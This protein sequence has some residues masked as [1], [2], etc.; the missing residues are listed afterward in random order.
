[1]S[2]S[3]FGRLFLSH[4]A[5]ILLTTLVLGLFMS[6]LVRNHAVRT[7]Q[8]DLLV[9][10]RVVSQL[11]APDLR[12]GRVPSAEQLQELEQLAGATLWLI[13]REGRVIAGTPPNRWAKAFPEAADE[14]SALFAGEAQTWV[15]TSRRQTDRSIV[16]G[17]AVPGANPQTA[18]LLY[19]S[20][21]GVN[22][23]AQAVEKLLLYSL[24]IGILAALAFALV[25]ARG[26]TRPVADIS[27]AAARF[28]GGDYTSRT[29]ATG[30]DELGR[31]G[32]TFNAMA[33]ALAHAEENRRKFLADVTHELKTPVASIQAM[34]EALQDGLVKDTDQQHRYLGT[35]VGEA[36][37][38]D[39]LLRDLLALAEL[40]AGA[41]SI[42]KEPLDLGY[43]WHEQADRL[44][45]L[46]SS[47][48]LT[49]NLRL[50]NQ[51]AVV[52]ADPDRLAQVALN[53]ITNAVRYAPAGSN[54]DVTI[55]L[56]PPNA[57]FT[58][59]DY[60]PGIPAAD[61]PH[62][63]ER[64]Y[65]VDKARTRAAGGTGLGLAIT[66]ELVRYM[67]GETIAESTPGQGAAFT[68]TLPLAGHIRRS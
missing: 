61:L 45:P 5:V 52:L 21:T 50:P 32:R 27:L 49:L 22:K 65:R 53:L 14:L 58:V 28:A 40:E 64:F 55:T 34:A 56:S 31:L 59:R 48:N 63:W 8:S 35:I 23:A 25:M 43:F 68:V 60:G 36:K 1:M 16:V 6:Y 20:I 24:G 39:R 2:R 26:L 13:D 30:D 11:L 4:V 19:A 46:L 44:A 15:R 41:L 51:P 12:Q 10:G 47:K 3:I 38:I 17:I 54:I 42:V 29:G 67:G 7:K 18:V 62:I 37:R 9:K 57:S 33:E 66:R